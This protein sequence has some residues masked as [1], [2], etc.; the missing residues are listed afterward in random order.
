MNYSRYFIF[1]IAL[2]LSLFMLLGLF[3]YFVNPYNI[4]A[5]ERIEGLNTFKPEAGKRVRTFKKYQP[6][7]QQPH[8]LIIGNS[9]VEMGLDP[10]HRVFSHIP[11]V[12]NL[13]VPGLGVNSQLQ[14]AQR[15]IQSASVKQVIIAIDFADFLTRTAH[16]F[17]PN[18]LHVQPIK[19]KYAALWSLD[20]LKASIVT[21]VRQ[22]SLGSNRLTNGFN[23][24]NDYIPIIQYEGQDVLF[25]QKIDMLHKMFKDKVW[26]QQL[27]L[28][29]HNSDLAILQQ[30][31]TPWIEQDITIKLF[32][33]P[34]HRDY[35]VTLAQHDL[36]T[37]FDDWRAL[38]AERF[39]HQV[40]FCD[41]TALG[42]DKSDNR[43][44]KSE[45]AFFWEPAHYKK[46]LGDIMLP[47]IVK[48]CL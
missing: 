14:Y 4:F 21:L 11:S 40:D 27:M 1:T 9:R 32:I 2:S 10:H 22:D 5:I 43:L 3:N 39:S 42:Y 15:V 8:T 45:L 18:V 31:L 41:F 34:Y 6:I 48:G 24:A 46:E 25:E 20:S 35:Y 13:G 7:Y 33:N 17:K 19:E 23:P 30:Y 47:Q 12:Y 28:N 16:Q 37:S 38:M 29:E 36:L 26:D 44:N